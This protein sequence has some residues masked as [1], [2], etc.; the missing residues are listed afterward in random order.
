MGTGPPPHTVVRRAPTGHRARHRGTMRCEHHSDHRIRR[1]PSG[2]SA[3]K[4]PPPW[5][6]PRAGRCP[7]W[8][9]QQ[10]RDQ[11]TAHETVNV[12]RRREILVRGGR[13]VGQEWVRTRGTQERQRTG[14]GATQTHRTREPRQEG[15]RQVQQ[16]RRSGAA[17][18]EGQ[19]GQ[20]E[21]ETRT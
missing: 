21:Q 20:R 4:P 2:P 14:G 1:T 18:Q 19:S 9:W 3:T 13:R 15:R 16:T 12:V 8:G 11:P 17:R 5:C 10:G 7:P 6:A